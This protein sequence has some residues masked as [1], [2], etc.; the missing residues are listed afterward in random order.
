MKYRY[1]KIRPEDV[2]KM[3]KF[4][5]EGLSYRKISEEFNIS[6]SVVQYHL[7]PKYRE[8]SLARSKKRNKLKPQKPNPEYIKK[9]MKERYNN[10]EEFR[11]RF[12]GLV[13]SSY[14]RRRE[15]WIEKGLCSG[16]GRE[17][18]DKN[19]KTCD[20]CRYTKRQKYKQH[21]I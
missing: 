4:R 10:D 3:K 15:S 12:I 21:K 13:T 2:E 18:E 6:M 16:C 1:R 14:K 19:L 17:R 8:Q 11:K 5:A 7:I 9:Y 20:K